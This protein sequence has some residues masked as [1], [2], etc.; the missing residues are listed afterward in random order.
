[1]AM[2]TAAAALLLMSLCDRILPAGLHSELDAM[3]V[4][5]VG[6]LR[7]VEVPSLDELEKRF[8]LESDGYTTYAG[9]ITEPFCEGDHVWAGWA[10]CARA[11]TEKA[12][13]R[14]EAW[15]VVF[16]LQMDSCPY[17]YESVEEF[18]R[19]YAG[20]DVRDYNSWDYEGGVYVDKDGNPVESMNKILL[21]RV[22]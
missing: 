16:A 10:L 6:S 8:G 5:A 20:Y 17:T 14:R 22:S 2:A 7:D 21:K 9:F 4:I 18:L 13:E 15:R 3:G 12:R 19:W 11:A 1:M